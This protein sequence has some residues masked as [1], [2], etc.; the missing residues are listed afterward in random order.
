MK[1]S[2]IMISVVLLVTATQIYAQNV[3]HLTGIWV[4][5]KVKVGGK[6]MSPDAKWTRLN[7]DFTQE[8]GNGW[9]QHS[10]GGWSFDENT[11]ELTISTTNGV[12]DPYGSFNVTIENDIMNWK[13]I[14][15]GM[16]VLVS[17]K[18]SNALPTAF[19]DKLLGLWGMQNSTGDSELF[20]G[21]NSGDSYLFIRWDGKY[22]I[23]EGK[24]K[25]YGVYNIHAHKPQ[26]EFIPYG[27]NKERS[28]WMIGYEDESLELTLVNSTEVVT[29]KFIRI[30]EFPE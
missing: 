24:E 28:F 3:D 14:E 12:L 22:V 17:L 25:Q 23:G 4:V 30:N 9:F 1:T 15:D 13:R 20:T 11:N 18:R 16:N 27:K 10:Y 19:R 26:V 7:V 2:R 5:E 29:R 8:S 6:E 21:N